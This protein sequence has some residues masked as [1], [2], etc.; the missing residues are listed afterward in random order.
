M[1]AGTIAAMRRSWGFGLLT[2]AAVACGRSN[3]K[4]EGPIIKVFAPEDA[5]P[6]LVTD[7]GPLGIQGQLLDQ[8]RAFSLAQPLELVHRPRFR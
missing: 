5:G 8:G 1:N 6:P 2:L 3:R 7:A 4:P